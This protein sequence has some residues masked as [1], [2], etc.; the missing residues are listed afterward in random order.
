MTDDEWN[1]IIR[2]ISHKARSAGRQLDAAGL[3]ETLRADWSLIVDPDARMSFCQA[4]DLAQ[5]HTA[6]DAKQAQL[7]ILNAEIEALEGN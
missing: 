1:C 7:E 6:R 4:E 3:L 5:L 2:V